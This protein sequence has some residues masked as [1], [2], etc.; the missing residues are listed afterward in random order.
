MI[1]KGGNAP[2]IALIPKRDNPQGLREFRLISLVG[3]MSF[4]FIFCKKNQHTKKCMSYY[5]WNRIKSIHAINYKM[6]KNSLR[7]FYL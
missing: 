3:C 1:L 5:P 2:F 7:Y 6:E 4:Y